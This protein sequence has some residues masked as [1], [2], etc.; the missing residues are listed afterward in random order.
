MFHFVFGESCRGCGLD[1]LAGSC[2]EEFLRELIVEVR[3]RQASELACVVLAG[4]SEGLAVQEF[5][6]ELVV[7][8]AAPSD[9]AGSIILKIFHS[10]EGGDVKQ[11]CS[12][13]ETN[14][15]CL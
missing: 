5:L 2:C 14:L 3:P 10:V 13:L 6:R 4:T 11:V 7:G 12:N 15:P 9:L 1:E 8:V